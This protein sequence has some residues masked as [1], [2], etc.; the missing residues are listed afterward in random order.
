MDGFGDPSLV[1]VVVVPVVVPEPEEADGHGAREQQG[2][3]EPEAAGARL[4]HQTGS[5][6]KMA[7][8]SARRRAIT[9]RQNQGV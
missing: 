2:E 5:L 3:R 9:G 4:G 8:G 7:A 6:R 1:G